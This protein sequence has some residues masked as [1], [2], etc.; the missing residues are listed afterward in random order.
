MKP[1]LTLANLSRLN[2]LTKYPSIPTYHAL[3]DKGRLTP[4]VN[5]AFTSDVHVTEKVDGTNARLVCTPEGVLI[6]SREDLLWAT[7]DLIHN[8]ALGIVDTL[9]DFAHQLRDHSFTEAVVVFYGEVYGHGV[10]AAAKQY[11]SQ[12]TRGF[13]LFDVC[14]LKADLVSDMLARP[15]EQISAWREHSG[16]TFASVSACD[17]LAARFGFARVPMSGVYSCDVWP[18]G[19]TDAR[20]FL[21]GFAESKAR[22]DGAALGKAEG[23][24]AR[25]ADRSQIAKLRFEDYQRTLGR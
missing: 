18:R 10:G 6:G 12:G 14:L 15:A 13:R 23:I 2:S 3:G 17:A 21:N 22:L 5:V 16:Q 19:L 24:V 9:R 11:A 8:P 7:G 25:T 4:E 1:L 20:D